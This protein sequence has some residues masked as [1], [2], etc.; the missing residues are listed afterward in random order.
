MI[1]AGPCNNQSHSRGF[2]K[3]SISS[4]TLEATGRWLNLVPRGVH[5]CGDPTGGFRGQFTDINEP[6]RKRLLYEK[7]DAIVESD[8]NLRQLKPTCVLTLTSVKCF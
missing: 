7:L 2:A 6:C 5:D 4:L 8:A 3:C 1:N